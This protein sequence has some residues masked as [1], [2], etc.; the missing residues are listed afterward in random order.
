MKRLL[1]FIVIGNFMF[2]CDNESEQT[3]GF[4][5]E[6]QITG[7]VNTELLLQRHV[8]GATIDMDTVSTD[9]T[10]KFIFTGKIN[11]P[12]MCTIKFKDTMLSFFLE[13]SNIKL[14]ADID[15]LNDM[16]LEGSESHDQYSEYKKSSQALIDR[17]AKLSD[18]YLAAKESGD[19]EKLNEVIK[20]FD[21]L[22]EDEQAF[23]R[24]Y[25]SKHTVSVVTP[26]IA[27]R[28]SY[29]LELDDLKEIV[30]S[31]DSTLNK[32]IY[33]QYLN[34]RISILETTAVGKP[35]PDFT[36]NDADGN[37]ISLSSFKGKYLLVDFWASWCSPCRRANP[38]VV[39][40]YSKYNKKGF[41]VLGVSFDS[42][43]ER[44]LD[45]VDKDGLTWSQ[46]S[47]LEGWNNSVG[48]L[49]GV[50]SIPHTMLVDPQGVI[51]AHKL[52]TDG[53]EKKLEDIFSK[54]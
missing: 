37:P 11:N 5:I 18:E 17:G 39:K 49:Y 10:G 34:K 6:G 27:Y 2:S 41:E 35:A 42:D 26:Y 16:K 12:E 14:N 43:K 45:A 21:Q 54:E 30:T 48:K 32:S 7:A 29:A 19:T 28:T 38:H 23:N 33:V 20:A 44:W 40:L 13:D 9:S 50:R 8:D 3:D 25:M 36:Q 53:L 4:K 15:S 31:L 22:D 1:I 52:D 47:D 51:I 46:V 24:D